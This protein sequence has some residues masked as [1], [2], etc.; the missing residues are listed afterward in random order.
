[1][2]GTGNPNRDAC[3]LISRI[4]VEE[5]LEALFA[6]RRSLAAVYYL[7]DHGR[8]MSLICVARFANAARGRHIG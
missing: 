3:T 8:D 7:F 4:I 2:P 5:L 6:T 1:M